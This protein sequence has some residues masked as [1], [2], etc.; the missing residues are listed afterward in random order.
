MSFIPSSE[1]YVE[2]WVKAYRHKPK[3]TVFVTIIAIAS[4]ATT[5]YLTDK[6][7][8]QRQEMQR[9]QNLDYA[10]QVQQLQQTEHSLQALIKFV[11]HQKQTLQQTQS[12]L[13]GLKLEQERLKPLI[14]SDRNTVE[15]ILSA[16]ER[17]NA[18]NIWRERWIGFAIGV[19][20]SLVASFL[21][22]VAARVRVGSRA[23]V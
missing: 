10:T 7:D 1:H 17:R 22:A 11:A 6:R 16:Q 15:A 13:I 4:M 12:N 9:L 3:V 14:E 2:L 20:A 23:K 21:W 8:R 18:A 19:L 5:I